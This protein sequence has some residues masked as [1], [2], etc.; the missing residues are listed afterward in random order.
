MHRAPPSYS[1]DPREKVV[2]NLK[3]QLKSTLREP[4]V[5]LIGYDT[6]S[7]GP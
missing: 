4:S 6:A 1:A 3:V 5:L 7:S 2:F